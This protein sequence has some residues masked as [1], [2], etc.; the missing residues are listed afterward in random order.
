MPVRTQ[1]NELATLHD[2][3]I[4]TLKLE[5]MIVAFHQAAKQGEVNIARLNRPKSKAKCH[6]CGKLGHK[7]FECRKRLREM[8]QHVYQPTDSTQQQQSAPG[9][10]QQSI[11]RPQSSQPMQQRPVSLSRFA[12]RPGTQQQQ[13]Q[14]QRNHVLSFWLSDNPPEMTEITIVSAV[15]NPPTNDYQDEMVEDTA[16][17]TEERF[18]V[19]CGAAVIIA[20]ETFLHDP[21]PAHKVATGIGNGTI[22]FS[23]SGT[24]KLATENG[25]IYSTKAFA[26]DDLPTNIFSNAEFTKTEDEHE[27]AVAA[28][29]QSHYCGDP[30]AT[31]FLEQD[32]HHYALFRVVRP[33]TTICSLWHQRLGHFGINKLRKLAGSLPEIVPP[34][35]NH[36]CEHCA[37]CKKP[38]PSYAT[39]TKTTVIGDKIH[40]DL[41]GRLEE[42]VLC[43]ILVIKDEAEMDRQAQNTLGFSGVK[44]LVGPK[45]AVNISWIQLRMET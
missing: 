3:D 37:T 34:P 41:T 23:S 38:R 28:Q 9:R 40:M 10:Q 44:T 31:S 17:V 30:L 43:Y 21:K 4:I 15:S 26:S 27:Y 20:N 25:L 24:L 16:T 12:R 42:F 35:D 1:V 8:A 2:I 19:D 18:L 39:R 6:D 33:A 45:L 29:R 5:D 14:Q 13:P 36:Y 22:S 7:Q 11:P 32:N